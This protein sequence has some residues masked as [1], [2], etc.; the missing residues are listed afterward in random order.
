MY[1][2]LKTAMAIKHITNESLAKL[3]G[4][5]RNTICN[6]LDGKTEFTVGQA[7]EI[8]SLFPEYPIAELFRQE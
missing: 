7:I 3:I 2:N 4:V 1:K 5:H 8:S 6:K